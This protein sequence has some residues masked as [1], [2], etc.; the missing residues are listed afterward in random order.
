M[1]KLFKRIV[2]VVVLVM[3]LTVCVVDISASAKGNKENDSIESE[4]I[5]DKDY[6]SRIYTKTLEIS[7][8]VTHANKCNITEVYCNGDAIEL[9]KAGKF[10]KIVN[11]STSLQTYTFQI[12]DT[13]GDIIDSKSV[14]ID[15]SGY[16]N[17]P[18]KYVLWIMSVF[19]LFAVLFRYCHR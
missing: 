7:G 5:L 18:I 14:S 8:C 11:A 13:N 17:R 4:I 16:Y 1:K 15:F 6:N 2:S 9:T 10:S 12:K 3:L 19:A